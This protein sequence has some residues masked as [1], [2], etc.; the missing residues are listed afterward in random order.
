MGPCKTNWDRSRSSSGGSYI[1]DELTNRQTEY[2]YQP[3]PRRVS[4]CGF[5]TEECIDPQANLLAVYSSEFPHIFLSDMSK[6][7]H[8][9]LNGLLNGIVENPPDPHDRILYKRIKQR[10]SFYRQ[11]GQKV[12]VSTLV[13]TGEVTDVI[14]KEKVDHLNLYCPNSQL[15]L[16][17]SVSTETK[18]ERSPYVVPVVT[19]V[20]F[21]TDAL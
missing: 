1:L 3:G 8:A 9:T 4:G 13:D 21:G 7:E 20:M 15:D 6:Q 17:I 16:R 14:Q 5:T 12:R 10:D 19:N 18:C 2:A 11:G